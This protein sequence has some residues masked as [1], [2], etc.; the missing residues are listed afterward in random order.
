LSNWKPGWVK[1]T[2][3]AALTDGGLSIRTWNVADAV[4]IVSN[5]GSNSRRVESSAETKARMAENGN[6]RN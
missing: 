3:A 6:C 4:V 2:L 1:Y 5:G